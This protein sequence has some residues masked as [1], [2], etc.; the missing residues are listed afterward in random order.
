[1][2]LA[3]ALARREANGTP[4]RVGLIGAG[5]FGTMILSQLRLMTGVRLCVLADLDGDR[6]RRALTE[7]G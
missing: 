1:M 4:V 2:N 5:K 7:A 3:R 6:A